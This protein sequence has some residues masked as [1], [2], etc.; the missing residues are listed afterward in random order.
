MLTINGYQIAKGPNDFA[1]KKALTVKP[2]S[3]INPH[4][5]P[6]YPVYCEDKHH[7]YLPKHYGIEKF[8]EVPSKRDVAET[9][10]KYWT[11]AGSIR[12]V[13]LP[14]VNSF[15]LPEPHDGIISL[16]TGGGKTVCALYIASRLRVPAL[17][18]VHNSFL[19][20]QW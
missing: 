9:D 13:Q 1:I 14:V 12:P 8:G 16:H 4:A 5:V 2:L 20:D 15:L 3:L 18:V 10:G 19:R 17:V 6:K 7:L 11:F